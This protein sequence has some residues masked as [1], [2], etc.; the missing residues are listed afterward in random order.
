ML[1]DSA[2]KNWAPQ[3]GITLKDGLYEVEVVNVAKN[4]D[5]F[6]ISIQRSPT[7]TLM[8]LTGDMIREDGVIL[9]P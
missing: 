3:W 2:G 1:S 9:K 6:W 5:E 8:N 7:C 4:Q